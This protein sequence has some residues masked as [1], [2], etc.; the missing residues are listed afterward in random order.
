MLDPRQAKGP[1]APTRPSL[2]LPASAQ[3]TARGID[4][5]RLTARDDGTVVDPTEHDAAAPVAAL[6]DALGHLPTLVGDLSPHLQMG[7]VLG[8]GGMGVVRAAVQAGLDREVAVKQLRPGH[9]TERLGQAL[10]REARVTGAIAHPNVVPVHVLGIDDD[11]RPVMV[12]KRVAG[13]GWD[14]IL[15]RDAPDAAARLDDGHLER[16][17]RI[18]GQVAYAVH[19]AHSRGIIHRDL[20]PA[21]VLVGPFGE[22]YV[23][24][25]GLAASLREDGVPGVPMASAITRVVGTPAYMAPEMAAGLGEYFGPQTDVYLLGAILYE[26]LM[27]QPPYEGDSPLQVLKAAYDGTRRPWDALVPDGLVQITERAM[28]RDP[29][30]R[31]PTVDALREAVEHWTRRAGTERLRHQAEARLAAL[32]DL[33]ASRQGPDKGAGP[34]HDRQIHR[35]FSE[36]RFGFDQVR[37]EDPDDALAVEGLQS[38]VEL[39]ISHE[40]AHGSPPHR[41]DP[42]EAPSGAGLPARPHRTGGQ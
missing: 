38:A 28:A 9:A 13:R 7:G 25:W 11:G 24:D 22:V 10:L 36:C 42:P 40:L 19:Y 33:V 32:E 15:S 1:E 6:G 8:E 23:V 34:H 2:D 4:P 17:L 16:Q 41:R 35:A 26:I 27:G 12:M 29:A 30:D 37:R 21:N 3:W 39:M 31:F 5:M 14:Q 18:L 20:K